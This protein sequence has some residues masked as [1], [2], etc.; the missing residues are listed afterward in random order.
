MS[1]SMS[2]GLAHLASCGE[3]TKETFLAPFIRSI[4]GI[5]I[6]NVNILG[7]SDSDFTGFSAGCFF[8]L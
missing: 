8:F 7:G 6:F 3:G 2:G 5:S 1:W 4:T